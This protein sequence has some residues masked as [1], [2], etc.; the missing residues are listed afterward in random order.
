MEKGTLL[1]TNSDYPSC[2]AQWLQRVKEP[3]VII[4]CVTLITHYGTL[5]AGVLATKGY[6]YP[7][8]L[9]Q[10]NPCQDDFCW[11]FPA[12]FSIYFNSFCDLRLYERERERKKRFKADIP[13]IAVL[14]G[15]W[16]GLRGREF[17]SRLG[18]EIFAFW[19][20][21]YGVSDPP[22]LL[23]TGYCCSLQGIKRPQL[24]VELTAIWCR[25]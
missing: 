1:M 19:K 11:G 21:S 15:V 17:E 5:A 20:R 25:G 12:N 24:E 9:A 2:T 3:E 22:C 10:I 7:P 6:F 16:H 18:P 23:F 4:Q 13:R 14:F 8:H